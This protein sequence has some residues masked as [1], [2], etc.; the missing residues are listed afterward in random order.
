[1][2]GIL[3]FLA[4]SLLW[5]CPMPFLIENKDEMG[6]VEL[7]TT[8]KSLYVNKKQPAASGGAKL[9]ASN[10]LAAVAC[11][12]QAET[13]SPHYFASYRAEKNL[14]DSQKDYRL[15]WLNT[16]QNRY[17]QNVEKSTSDDSNNTSSESTQGELYKT[18]WIELAS[19]LNLP[20]SVFNC[21][22]LLNNSEFYWY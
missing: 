3:S 13:L 4:T 2:Q 12:L 7:F 17:A 8:M 22:V 11:G 10:M 16:F 19:I 15:P 1:M 9:G 20:D 18:V 14:N 6:A 5:E 21:D